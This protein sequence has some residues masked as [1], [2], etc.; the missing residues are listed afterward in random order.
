MK[1]CA[2]P[3]IKKQK[4]IAQKLITNTKNVNTIIENTQRF[5]KVVLPKHLTIIFVNT[6]MFSV[7]KPGNARVK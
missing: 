3:I 4:N 1:S 5:T 2:L 6:E 7:I